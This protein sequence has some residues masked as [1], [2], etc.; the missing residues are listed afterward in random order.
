MSEATAGALIWAA[1]CRMDKIGFSSTGPTITTCTDRSPLKAAVTADDIFCRMSQMS[2][3]WSSDEDLYRY[4]VESGQKSVMFAGINTDQCVLSTITDVHYWG[5][6]CILLKDCSGIR[7]SPAAQEV[8]EYNMATCIG[9]V[10]DSK[11]L[12]QAKA[13]G[14]SGI[15]LRHNSGMDFI[16]STIGLEVDSAFEDGMGSP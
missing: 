8:A 11:G 3:M 13:E 6:D 9:F 2:G 4:L 10:S 12:V 15:F 1:N 5:W 14:T 7:T 16:D